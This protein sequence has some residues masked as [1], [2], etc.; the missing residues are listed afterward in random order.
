MQ[1]QFNP[2]KITI[3]NGDRYIDLSVPWGSTL[4]DWKTVF[5]TILI[6][7]TFTENQVFD[8][9]ELERAEDY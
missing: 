2:T 8:F 4:E 3:S 5:K 1:T 6:F 9:F 7:E